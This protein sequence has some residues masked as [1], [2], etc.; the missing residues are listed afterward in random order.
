MKKTASLVLAL[1]LLL[2]FIPSVTAME[3][4]IAPDI[5]EE[6][7]ETVSAEEPEDR[8]EVPEAFMAEEEAETEPDVPAV[9]AEA[10]DDTPEALETAEAVTAFDEGIAAAPAASSGDIEISEDNFLNAAF[11]YY[12]RENIDTNEDGYLSDDEIAA[13]TVIDLAHDPY[14]TESGWLQYLNGIEFFYNLKEL[15]CSYNK[16]QELDV[17]HNTQLEILECGKNWIAE[18]DLSQ[19]PKLKSLSCEKTEITGLD[20]SHNPLLQSLDCKNSPLTSLNLSKCTAL[21]ML[22]CSGCQLTKLN[23]SKNMALTVLDCSQNS[24]STLNL[25]GHTNLSSVT[26]RKNRLTSLDLGGCTALGLVYCEDNRLTELDLRDCP[27][28]IQ[29]C[30]DGYVFTIEGL[31]WNITNTNYNCRLSLDV[32]TQILSGLA[33]V[34]PTITKQ[35]ADQTPTAGK[36]VTLTVAATG[37]DLSYRWQVSKDGGK[38]WTNCT[39]AGNSSA[40]FSFTFKASYAGWMYRCLVFSRLDGLPSSAATLLAKPSV[41]KQPADAETDVSGKAVFQVTATGGNLS[42]QW[43]VSKDGGTTW[44]NCTST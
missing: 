27:N 38:T 5:P 24:L 1:F 14:A 12:I 39:S 43:Q 35:P 4:E 36:K 30:R 37:S 8:E 19:N 26:C 22:D 33:P 20:L 44:K 23:L 2:Q 31:Y 41:T 16:V 10:P 34:Y 13:V 6:I 32:G 25:A 15:Y 42:Y 28:L 21:Q 29:Y 3:N 9:S 7:E 11:R 17:T 40:S 18:L